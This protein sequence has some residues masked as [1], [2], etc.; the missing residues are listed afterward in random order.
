MFAD[1][2]PAVIRTVVPAAV[3]AFIS[4]LFG[5]GI[6]VDSEGENAINKAL[7]VLLIAAYYA[8]ATLLE[9]RVSPSFGWLL[10]M[11]KTPAYSHH[12]PPAAAPVV[13]DDAGTTEGP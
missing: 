1:A 12:S 3:G 8:L 7:T 13:V 4:W 10:G 2:V 5:I 6:Q 9:R 11:A